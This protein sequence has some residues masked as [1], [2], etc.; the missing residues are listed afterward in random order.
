MSTF[1]I[2]LKTLTLFLAAAALFHLSFALT[3]PSVLLNISL[4]II[5]LFVLLQGCD[6][7][8]NLLGLGKYNSNPNQ[9]NN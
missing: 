8:D 3:L 2:T 6:R 9:K 5:A 7:L 4:F 1:K